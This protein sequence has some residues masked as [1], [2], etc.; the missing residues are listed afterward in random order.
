MRIRAARVS[1]A[2]ALT[3]AMAVA[4]MAA[5][6]AGVGSLLRPVIGTAAAPAHAAA[7]GLPGLHGHRAH[8][9]V[10][11]VD[12]VPAPAILLAA[13]LLVAVVV[14]RFRSP[15]RVAFSAAHARGP[16]AMR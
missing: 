1:L 6:H 7:A 13:L 12:V 3:A 14:R 2:F 4:G 15:M 10:P 8:E 16:P 5:S 9:R 11:A